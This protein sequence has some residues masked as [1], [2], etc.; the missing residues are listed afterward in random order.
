[1]PG[2]EPEVWPSKAKQQTPPPQPDAEAPEVWPTPKPK[3]ATSSALPAEA[4]APPSLAS[5]APADTGLAVHGSLSTQYRGRWADAQH[6]NDLYEFLAV[7]IG[8]PNR[9][10]WTAHMSARMAI[11][12]DGKP[13]GSEPPLFFNL[14]DTYNGAV[15]TRL[16]EAHADGTDIGPLAE[17]KLGRQ[18]E[19]E[20]PVYAWLDGAYLLSKPIGDHNLE[21][22][23]Y[24]GIPVHMYESST[25]GD[26]IG[27]V[28]GQAKLWSDARARLDWMHLDDSSET[29]DHV[30]NLWKLGV[31]QDIG[32][33]WHLEGNYSR[34]NDHNRD[35]TVRGT[36]SD[37]EDNL[38]V[39]GAFYQLLEGQ[40][41]LSLELD[42]FFTAL[43]ELFPYY[44]GS[45]LVSK[46]FGNDVNVQ[47][48]FDARRVTD[49]ADLGEFNHDF[50]RYFATVALSHILPSEL[51]LSGTGEMWD[52]GGTGIAS[53]GADLA[54]KFDG[55]WDTSIGTYFSLYKADL[56]STTERDNVRTYYLRVRYRHSSALT[57]DLRYEYESSE[58]GPFNTLIL[59][60]V[61][62]F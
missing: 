20:T 41:A 8:D 45:L 36:Y 5:A 54:R 1:M 49:D 12:L 55:R 57:W 11:D 40:K 28:F 33:A 34:L 6:D 24:G 37:L 44:D 47:A 42:P 7:D 18:I 22:G 48:G 14:A 32:S 39:Q 43:G 58:F 2:Q 46:G 16:Y 17:L 59:G 50:D 15:Y 35:F 31:W 52:G 53:W 56:F 27:G 21:F 26:A 19:Y 25:N 29:G 4:P 51:V 13:S 3:A 60:L 38:T 62:H 30:D 9:D 61:W 23:G 10:K